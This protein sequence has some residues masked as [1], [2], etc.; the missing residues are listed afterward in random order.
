MLN[1]TNPT[2]VLIGRWQMIRAELAGEV[3]PELVTG[4]MILELGEGTYAVVYAGET[5]DSGEWEPGPAEG[6]M[7]LNGRNGPN[8]GRRIPCLYQQ[9]GDRLRVCYGLDGVAPVDFTTT[10]RAGRYSASYRRL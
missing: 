1:P 6:T 5:S 3:A 4:R 7:I 10:G 8:A 9:V 2:H